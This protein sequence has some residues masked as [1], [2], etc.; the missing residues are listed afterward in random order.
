MCGV[1]GILSTEPASQSEVERM[2][3]A[4]I[5]RGP[6]DIGFYRDG[7]FHGGM[8]RLSIND[9]EGGMQPSS[10]RIAASPFFTTERFITAQ[11]Y[12]RSLRQRVFDLEL[13]AMER[14]F[15]IS[16]RESESASL[17][18]LME[19]LQSHSGM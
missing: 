7:P 10:M 5:H 8:R 13:E 18:I 19:C 2:L 17:S 12:V 9:V 6:D 3:E 15:A 14:S 16:T 4:L 1:A 11:G